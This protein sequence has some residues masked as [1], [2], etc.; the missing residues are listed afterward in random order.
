MFGTENKNVSPKSTRACR[1][2]GNH[3]LPCAE[4]ESEDKADGGQRLARPTSFSIHEMNRAEAREKGSSA[5]ANTDA[6]GAR[7]LSIYA[8]T[9]RKLL[10]SRQQ[11][12]SA[13]KAGPNLKWRAVNIQRPKGVNAEMAIQS[14]ERP[15]PRT[16]RTHPAEA[17][18]EERLQTVIRSRLQ[19]AVHL[20]HYPRRRTTR[21]QPRDSCRKNCQGAGVAVFGNER[22][23]ECKIRRALKS[24]QEDCRWTGARAGAQARI[25]V[26]SPM[27]AFQ[28]ELVPVENILSCAGRCQAFVCPCN[29]PEASPTT[30]Q[31]LSRPRYVKSSQQR[32]E[33]V[34]RLGSGELPRKPR[35]SRFRKRASGARLVCGLA[36]PAPAA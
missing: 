36:E 13:P 18:A 17:H 4:R 21:W 11:H 10:K 25:F 8:T 16:Q 31:S 29:S 30:A 23:C 5:R 3:K 34:E 9:K 12:K 2:Q 1:R 35:F 32:R 22:F 19:A 33:D 24:R 28:E 7:E 26:E 20:G 27:A 6:I 14:S 15:T